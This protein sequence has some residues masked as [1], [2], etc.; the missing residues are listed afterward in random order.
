MISEVRPVATALVPASIQKRVRTRV[1]RGR[2]AIDEPIPDRLILELG[3][4]VRRQLVSSGKLFWPL[5][6]RHCRKARDPLK[7]TSN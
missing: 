4:L 7:V 6:W 1:F 5:Q 2:R 3:F